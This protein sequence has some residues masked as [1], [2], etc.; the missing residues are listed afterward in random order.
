VPE[1]TGAMFVE[2]GPEASLYARAGDHA[3]AEMGSFETD[4]TENDDNRVFWPLPNVIG[5]EAMP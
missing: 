4:F 5:L 2:G 1:L 3:V